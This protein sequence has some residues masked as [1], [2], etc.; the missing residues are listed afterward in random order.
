MNSTFACVFQFK[1]DSIEVLEIIDEVDCK[2]EKSMHM[3]LSDAVAYLGGGIK[4]RF[5]S[6]E[7]IGKH[8]LPH[9]YESIRDMRKLAPLRNPEYATD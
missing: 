6:K 3:P 2:R 9:F 4:N 5:L 7:K 8:V 1:H